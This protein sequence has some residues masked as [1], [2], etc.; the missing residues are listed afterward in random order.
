MEA[1]KQS[2]F[3]L[4]SVLETLRDWEICSADISAAIEFC[5]EKI[6]EWS[7]D[8]FEEWFQQRFPKVGIR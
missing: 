1:T 5:R 4:C 6:V 8:E 7:I 2:A 3:K